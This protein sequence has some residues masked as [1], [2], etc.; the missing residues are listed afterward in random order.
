MSNLSIFLFNSQAIRILSIDGKTWF[1]A[2]DVCAVLEHTNTSV[3][4]GR[5]KEYEKRLV[6]PKQYLG[7]A[8][9]QDVAVI[10]ESGLY[11]LVLTSRKPQAEPFQDWV[12]Q[13][14]LPAIRKTGRFE[15]PRP[16][17]LPSRALLASREVKE[18]HE[19]I[20]DISP[21]LKQYLV[22][23]CLNEVIEKALPGSDEPRLRGVAEIAKDMK[24]PI[25]HKNRSDLGKFV[26]AELRHLAKTEKRLCNG[27]EQEIAVYPDNPL[28]RE[29]IAKFFE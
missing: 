6:D 24:L 27:T 12:C 7:S 17:Y 8:S 16:D 19:N 21:R 3:A 9:N 28:V 2:A 11:R 10:S 20:E 1:V 15:A 13:E 26:K 25:N 29:R 4:L 18:I 5:L 23:C 14:V 22:D